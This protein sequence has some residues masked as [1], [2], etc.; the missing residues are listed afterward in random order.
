[1]PDESSTVAVPIHVRYRQTGNPA[2]GLTVVDYPA[3]GTG[4]LPNYGPR[5]IFAKVADG[6][7][8]AG[9]HY[10]LHELAF[11][12]GSYWFKKRVIVRV[13]MGPI[14]LSE[15]DWPDELRELRSHLTEANRKRRYV[16]CAQQ[17]LRRLN[18]R[19]PETDDLVE[20]NTL[21][22]LTD[23][24]LIQEKP[25][26]DNPH[27][28][29]GALLIALTS[30]FR[31][32]LNRGRRHLA[33]GMPTSD[34]SRELMF[35]DDLINSVLRWIDA[36]QRPS[37]PW[38]SSLVDNDSGHPGYFMRWT[39]HGERDLGSADLNYHPKQH[40]HCAGK[41]HL[42]CVTY[43]PAASRLGEMNWTSEPS[44]DEYSGLISGLRWVLQMRCLA[45]D[46]A[47]HRTMED[48]A[49]YLTHSAGFLVRPSTGDLVQRGPFIVANAFPLSL[50]L[51]EPA[52]NV[53]GVRL[54]FK[55]PQPLAVSD[56][57]KWIVQVSRA[58]VRRLRACEA[59]YIA[60]PYAAQQR[61]LADDYEANCVVPLEK[62]I[63]VVEK[64]EAADS[65]VT[66]ALNICSATTPFGFVWA[67]R[68]LEKYE[69]AKQQLFNEVTD[70]K[71]WLLCAKAL[72]GG[73]DILAGDYNVPIFDRY[74]LAAF[75]AA[76]PTL[77][78]AFAARSGRPLDVD[79]VRQMTEQ[80]Y[81]VWFGASFDVDALVVAMDQLRQPPNVPGH[82]EYYLEVTRDEVDALIAGP[83]DE[84]FKPFMKRHH[85]HPNLETISVDWQPVGSEIVRAI[86][87]VP[88]SG[89]LHVQL[90]EPRLPPDSPAYLEG[91]VSGW[92]MICLAL[93][94]D[95][96][97]HF[98]GLVSPC[99]R[100]DGHLLPVI[101]RRVA[102]VAHDAASAQLHVYLRD[103]AP[104]FSLRWQRMITLD[105]IATP[106]F[107]E[108]LAAPSL[109]RFL[110]A[111]ILYPR[112]P[113]SLHALIGPAT[114][115]ETHHEETHPAFWTIPCVMKPANGFPFTMLRRHPGE[116]QAS[117]RSWRL[118]EEET[119]Q[120]LF[121]MVIGWDLI[122]QYVDDLL[123]ADPHEPPSVT[124]IEIDPDEHFDEVLEWFE[125]E[126]SKWVREGYSFE[127]LEE[128]VP[129]S[130]DC[131]AVRGFPEGT[132]CYVG[133]AL[134]RVPAPL[135]AAEA[136]TISVELRRGNP[137]LPDFTR[138]LV[139]V[140]PWTW[141]DPL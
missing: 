109:E 122:R 120:D 94:I 84:L 117:H 27:I 103:P 31:A 135:P 76:D 35:L 83:F 39:K 50:A 14:E 41:H 45:T 74:C 11:R 59:L 119:N 62:A 121:L 7:G 128:F 72:G 124:V 28:I 48:I 68:L 138:L 65:V 136:M 129:Y 32:C 78:E 20:L 66:W 34:D 40:L 36:R 93:D 61:A 71:L 13:G 141:V 106:V 130:W 58:T 51:G 114:V 116:R 113:K 37:K 38:G 69:D 10:E 140:Q 8:F 70:A 67:A 6:E 82:V 102:Y 75:W 125:I 23:P 26:T 19:A 107:E 2:I 131:A 80:A 101:A 123:P 3:V 105:E 4:T 91:L 118:T 15:D 132:D 53:G 17:V 85:P 49:A 30:C 29:A 111:R 86:A 79:G 134:V 104:V 96:E 115:V 137:P 97:L 60:E 81:R 88:A 95:P 89:L 22:K 46:V 21:A 56:R 52:V 139:E 90:L 63:D 5:E 57:L 42:P 92:T 9:V 108:M 73:P 98:D 110:E 55:I 44:L 87:Y 99:E 126:L 18:G 12:R 112:R 64:L 47:L 100:S 43:D 127:D 54:N 16:H 77:E 1:M 133:A 33:D 25:E 24:A